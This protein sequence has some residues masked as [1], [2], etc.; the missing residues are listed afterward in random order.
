M[1]CL[2]AVLLAAGTRTEDAKALF[3]RIFEVSA[4]GRSLHVRT[5]PPGGVA[6][7]VPA[8]RKRRQER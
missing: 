8:H 2:L 6:F 7:S 4:D 1:K 5:A 3:E